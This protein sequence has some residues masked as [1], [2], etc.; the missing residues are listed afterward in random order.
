MIFVDDTPIEIE[1]GRLGCPQCK[2]P[3]VEGETPYHHEGLN[4]GSFDG[5]VCE[6][7]DYGLLTEKGYED[8]DKAIAALGAMQESIEAGRVK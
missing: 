2:T 6:T 5:L 4:I 3:L 1:P 8:S 7:C